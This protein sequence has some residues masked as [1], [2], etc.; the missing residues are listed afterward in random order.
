M[1][2]IA[3]KAAF[4]VTLFAL[5]ALGTLAHA[6]DR[7][8]RYLIETDLGKIQIELLPHKAPI[9]VDNFIELADGGFYDGLIFHRVIAGFMVQTGGFDDEM[10]R[11]MSPRLLPNESIGGLKNT[12]GTLAMA[13]L[14]DPNSASSQFFINLKHNRHLDSKRGEPGYTVFGRVVDGMD[15]VE[16]IELSDTHIK[17]GMADVPETPIRIASVSRVEATAESQ[18]SGDSR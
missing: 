15:V 17:A 11:R 7:A 12:R 16:Q 9:T 5:S 6:E 14:P 8:P 10:K 1:K 18:A 3:S 4:A 13:R 2:P